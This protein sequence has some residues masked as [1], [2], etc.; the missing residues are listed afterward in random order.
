MVA[1]F[2]FL[3]RETVL[4][5]SHAITSPAAVQ[6]L[7]L[8]AKEARSYATERGFNAEIAMLIDMDLESGQNRFFVYN[9]LK[10]SVID[11]GLV[12]HGRCNEDWLLGRKYDN[13]VGSGCTSLGRY[14]IGHAYKGKFGLAYKL[15]GLDS[16][17]NNAFRRYV[18]LHSHECVPEREVDP[19]PICQSD[20]CPTVSKQ[21]LTRLTV[22]IDK[23]SKPVLLWI[24][25]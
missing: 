24:Y 8:Q 14:K 12:T 21:F 16:T 5:K 23:S 6:R 17:N 11:K 2:W 13:T 3:S 22:V 20:G 18:V 19:I 1:A 10:D 25:D 4:I 15:T 7:S 9:T